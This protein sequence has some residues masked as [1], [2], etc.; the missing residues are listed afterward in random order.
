MAGM[1]WPYRTS[2]AS[3]IRAPSARATRAPLT[4][5]TRFWLQRRRGARQRRKT[6]CGTGARPA[7]RAP[8]RCLARRNVRLRIFPDPPISP[9]PLCTAPSA[10]ASRTERSSPSR[11]SFNQVQSVGK[12]RGGGHERARKETGSSEELEA[13]G[14]GL[15]SCAPILPADGETSARDKVVSRPGSLDSQHIVPC[16]STA[17]R[18]HQRNYAMFLMTGPHSAA[19]APMAHL[20]CAHVCVEACASRCRIPGAGLGSQRGVRGKCSPTPDL[21]RCA[22]LGP[23]P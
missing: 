22:D 21:P 3:P 16:P 10:N 14:R 1:V 8:P 20:M 23:I 17:R 12:R 19:S 4:L 9:A 18:Q 6:R 5:L 13:I 15:P 11:G 7:R 2:R